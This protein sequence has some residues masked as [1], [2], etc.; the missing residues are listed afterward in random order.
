M[1]WIQRI[2]I[3]WFVVFVK[4]LIAFQM[5]VV[6]MNDGDDEKYT[7]VFYIVCINMIAHLFNHTSF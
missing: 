1:S 2:F 4:I 5:N 3:V 7:T 6:F